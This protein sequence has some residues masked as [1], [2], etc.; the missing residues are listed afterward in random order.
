MFSFLN[1][2]SEG[3]GV[4]RGHRGRPNGGCPGAL[5]GEGA[6]G[7]GGTGGLGVCH[8]NGGAPAHEER[9]RCLTLDSTGICLL[10]KEI[11]SCLTWLSLQSPT[12]NNDPLH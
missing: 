4:G 12:S 3:G 6:M 10:K 5:G 8:L 9:G 1:V 11:Q 7:G 2:L